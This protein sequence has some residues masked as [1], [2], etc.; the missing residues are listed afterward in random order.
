MNL[1]SKRSDHLFNEI[2]ASGD[3]IDVIITTTS[4]HTEETM[5]F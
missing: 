5:S 1:Q 3:G 4:G 2:Q